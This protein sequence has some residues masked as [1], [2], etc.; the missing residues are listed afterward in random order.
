MATQTWDKIENSNDYRELSSDDQGRVKKLYE[1]EVVNPARKKLAAHQKGQR[2]SKGGYAESRLSTMRQITDLMLVGDTLGAD[3]LAEKAFGDEYRAKYGFHKSHRG[4]VTR[5]DD[6]KIRYGRLPNSMANNYGGLLRSKETPGSS[7]SWSP[8]TLQRLSQGPKKILIASDKGAFVDGVFQTFE[9]MGY[10]GEPEII[11]KK[12]SDKF[13]TQTEELYIRD[14]KSGRLIPVEYG[15]GAPAPNPAPNPNTMNHGSFTPGSQPPPPESP[16]QLAMALRDRYGDAATDELIQAQIERVFGAQQSAPMQQ[17][18]QQAA[19]MEQQVATAG[20]QMHG[21]QQAPDP[22]F[23]PDLMPGRLSQSSAPAG[24]GDAEPLDEMGM[25]GPQGA[26]I[27]EPEPQAAPVTVNLGGKSITVGGT[28]P[29]EGGDIYSG[30]DMTP[31]VVLGG[32]KA[33]AELIGDAGTSAARGARDAR[34]GLSDM[35][36]Q[37]AA[38]LSDTLTPSAGRREA[39]N[40][41]RVKRVRAAIDDGGNISEDDL[42]RAMELFEWLPKK[43]KESLVKLTGLLRAQ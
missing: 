9:Q 34:V 10:E 2:L 40:D 3:S 8:D 33:G 17:A 42:S 39:Q 27:Q 26:V 37:A 29:T 30:L 41:I 38:R 31:D 21:A 16:E 32:M 7:M 18:P 13:G 14:P 1:Q 22:M 25:P 23:E 24:L 36:F 15:Q 20:V 35:A 6:G 28:D 19:P 11:K 4:R 5:G 43:Y 12:G